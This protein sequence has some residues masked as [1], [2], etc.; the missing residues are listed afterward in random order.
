VVVRQFRQA[1][2]AE[3]MKRLDGKAVVV[4]RGNSGF[5]L[6][7]ATCLQQ[8]GAKVAISGRNEKTLNEAGKT[9]GTGV[10]ADVAKL[11]DLDSEESTWT[12][13]SGR[14]ETPAFVSKKK[15]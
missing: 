5:G 3:T 1:G 8:K 7:R 4:T 11:T 10:L 2:L 15:M 14:S 6:A 13:D 9:I 12:A